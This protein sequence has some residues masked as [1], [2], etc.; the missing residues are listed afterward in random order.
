MGTEIKVTFNAEMDDD[1]PY[2]SEN[3]I[4]CMEPIKPKNGEALPVVSLVGFDDLHRGTQLLERVLRLHLEKWWHLCVVTG[5]ENGDVVILNEDMSLVWSAT[6]RC[7]ISQSFIIMSC[8]RGS[9]TLMHVASQF[10]QIGGFCR[11]I[12]KPGGPSRLRSILDLVIHYKSVGRATHS[13]TPSVAS[14]VAGVGTKTNVGIER[15]SST[16]SKAP[17]PPPSRESPHLPGLSSPDESTQN[18]SN[19]TVLP[20]TLAI[21]STGDTTP[22]AQQS[23]GTPV[24]PDTS[25]SVPPWDILES[26]E[27]MKPILEI[28]AGKRRNG[29]CIFT[30]KNPSTE[31][32]S[33]SAR[34]ET[35]A[36]PPSYPLQ[37]LM[38][39]TKENLP[40]RNSEFSTSAVVHVGESGTLLKSSLQSEPV[41]DE[42]KLRVLVVEDNGIL[43]NLL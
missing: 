20:P 21:P 9:P 42:K 22:N 14:L 32:N 10:E 26:P 1:D 15:S 24:T 3:E 16:E 18:K 28:S 31:A 40:P 8:A 7:D 6:E 17:G 27:R 43:R 2:E 37:L 4:N 12:Y 34:S 29:E 25:S 11:I 13:R 38:P 19:D 33:E 35:Y 41:H 30:L 36:A 39:L 23:W 5:A